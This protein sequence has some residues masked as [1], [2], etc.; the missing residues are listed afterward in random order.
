MRFFKFMIP[1]FAIWLIGEYIFPV[2][3]TDQMQV[4]IPY[5][6]QNGWDPE[7]ITGPNSVGRLIGLPLPLLWGILI[8]K[9]GPKKVF[10][11]SLFLY[12]VAEILIAI[13]FPNYWVFCIG[14]G[15][16]PGLGTCLLMSTFSLVKNWFRSWR[17]TALGIVTFISPIGNATSFSFMNGGTNSIGFTPTLLM[18][19]GAIAVVALIGI[20]I[21]RDTPEQL[22]C[23]PDGTIDPAPEEKLHDAALV[24]KINFLHIF[25]HKEAW[26]HIFMFGICGMALVCYPAFFM[27]RY[28][29]LGFTEGQALLFTY[30][31]SIFG[32][33]LS[34]LSGIIDDKLGTRNATI[35]IFALFFV[36]TICLRFGSVDNPWMIWIGTIA[37]GGIVGAYP[38]LN[39]SMV[40]YVYGRKSFD[41]VFMYMNTGVYILP[42]IG[43]TFVTKLQSIELA[44]AADPAV[45]VGGGFN[46]PYFWMI[47]ISLV[48]LI[49]VI[50]SNKKVDLTK[51]VA[52]VGKEA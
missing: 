1:A 18:V 4:L 38:N 23:H 51:D 17:G 12:G 36:G 3:A 30:G 21:V 5:F 27:V 22:G 35:M 45:V 48:G 40:A 6:A 8:I 28:Q 49:L 20:F 52:K 41:R 16:I 47:P 13:S 15:A 46:L 19:G 9:L 10:V 37:L 24:E 11:A 14:M 25:R 2:F 26:A 34:L 43:M 50:I 44:S 39:P 42:A 32:G 29:S 33:V 7:M 31:F